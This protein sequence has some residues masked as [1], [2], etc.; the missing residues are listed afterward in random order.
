MKLVLDLLKTNF[1]VIRLPPTK[2]IPSS[3]FSSE[4]ASFISITKTTDELS[5]VCPESL[6]GNVPDATIEKGWVA[7]KVR[8]PLDFSWTGILAGLAGPLA[9][10]QIS[11]FAISTYDTD[12][13]LVKDKVAE[14]TAD[15]FRKLG[16][17]VVENE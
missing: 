9:E 3:I 17:T 1:A 14:K 16:H 13:V 4:S 11:I 12:Y 7:F 2:S 6:I 15:V 8:G 5:I 10:S